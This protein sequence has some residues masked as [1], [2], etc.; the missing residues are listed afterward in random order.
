MRRLVVEIPLVEF[1]ALGEG[2]TPLSRIKSAETLQLLRYDGREFSMIVRI[3]FKA[4]APPLRDVRTRD[5]AMQL[6]EESSGSYTYFTR[7][8][9]ATGSPTLGFFGSDGYFTTPFEVTDGN[10]KLTFV[11][12]MKEIRQFLDSIELSGIKHRVASVADAKFSFNSPLNG[13]TE[14]QRRVLLTAYELGYYSRPRRISSK[15]LAR[16][17]G[18]ASSTFVSHRLKAERNLVAS[19]LNRK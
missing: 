10:L 2:D 18:L 12:S 5:Y 8:R 14:K 15:E 16:R 7:C 4:G 13:L 3:Q 19:V 6:L 17:L 11:G 9:V 1:D